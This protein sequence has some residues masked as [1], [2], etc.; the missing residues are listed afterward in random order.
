MIITKTIRLSR[1]VKHSWRTSI[2][3]IIVTTITY[4][5]N[6]YFLNK[7]FEFPPFVHA[8]IGPALAFF[9]MFNNNKAYERW[10]EARKI[11]GTLT[12]ASRNWARHIKYNTSAGQPE[13]ENDLNNLR[14]RT[15]FRHIAFLYI[16]KDNLREEKNIYYKKFLT[17]KEVKFVETQSNVQNAILNNQSRDLEHMYRMDYLDGFKFIEFDKIIT[18]FCNEMGKS[19]RIKNTVF[20]TIYN[21]YTRLFIWFLVIGITLSWADSTGLWSILIGVFVGYIF[22][23]TQAVGQLLMN[24]FESIPAGIPLDQIT[25]NIEINLLQTLG[26]SKIPEPIGKINNEYI[27]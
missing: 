5:I 8:I 4:F 6:E 11:W 18:V 23:I 24:P 17:P 25:R 10:W 22:L 3:L 1:L 19:E 16:L 2:L 9:I 12:N 13:N 26:E 14:R 7:Y 21:F 27:M 15:I 20:P